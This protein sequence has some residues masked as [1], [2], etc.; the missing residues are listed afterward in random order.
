MASIICDQIFNKEPLLSKCLMHVIYEKKS[1]LSKAVLY[2]HM[3][4]L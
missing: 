3:P 1:L 2:T 4:L